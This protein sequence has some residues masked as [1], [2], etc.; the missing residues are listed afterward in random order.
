MTL[1]QPAT[2]PGN[3]EDNPLFDDDDDDV[4]TPGGSEPNNFRLTPYDRLDLGI[5]YKRSRVTAKRVWRSEWT[6]FVY[7][8]LAKRNTYFAYRSI[9]PVTK[10]AMVK[11]VSF[12]PVIPGLSYSLKF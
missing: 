6:L 9:D 5:R 10:Q 3:P 2:L 8:V 11:Q 7:N 1:K 4:G 12:I